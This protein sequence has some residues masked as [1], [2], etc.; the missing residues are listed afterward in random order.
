MSLPFEIKTLDYNASA[1]DLEV[2]DEVRIEIVKGENFRDR[3][4]YSTDGIIL[5]N[6]GSECSVRFRTKFGTEQTLDFSN[7]DLFAKDTPVRVK[8]IRSYPKFNCVLIWLTNNVVILL[9]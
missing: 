9:T 2:G 8:W 1:K 6:Y 7:E 3:K 4:V 5:N